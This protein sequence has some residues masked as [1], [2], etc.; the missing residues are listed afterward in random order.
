M[1]AFAGYTKTRGGGY[2]GVVATYKTQHPQRLQKTVSRGM[3]GEINL[4]RAGCVGAGNIVEVYLYSTLGIGFLRTLDQNIVVLLIHVM[5]CD[6]TL[7]GECKPG[8]LQISLAA[9]ADIGISSLSLL[10]WRR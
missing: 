8:F 5:Q 4:Q 7:I 3:V 2:I 9:A 1:I 10:M 6:C